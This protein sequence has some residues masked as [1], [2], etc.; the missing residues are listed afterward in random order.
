MPTENPELNPPSMLERV[1]LHYFRKRSTKFPARQGDEVYLLDADEMLALKRIE[2]LAVVRAAIAGATSAAIAAAACYFADPLL[3]ELPSDA[4]FAQQWKYWLI[5][6]GV[7]CV[8]TVAEILFLYWDALRTVHTLACAAGLDLFPKQGERSAVVTSLV[9][10]AL[11]LPLPPETNPNVQ[12]GRNTSW[13]MLFI[14]PLIYKTK[15]SLTSFLIKAIVRR[16]A[17]R[18]ITRAWIEFVAVPVCAIWNAVVC[19]WI[20]REARYRAMGPS[21]IK[22]CLQQLYDRNPDLS[23]EDRLI[24]LDAVASVISRNVNLHPNV[25]RLY[26]EVEN[27]VDGD[28]T[29]NES[30]FQPEQFLSQLG[31][32]SAKQQEFQIGLL[33]LASIIDGHLSP[34]ELELVGDA[35]EV[36]GMLRDPQRLKMLLAFFRS[37]QPIDLG[38]LV[39]S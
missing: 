20:I 6:M 26:R 3:D 30:E 37:G 15:V 16:Y 35:R 7:T 1:G 23:D 5:V 21:A 8:V 13:L 14:A 18:V 19:W 9:Q 17:G 28:M 29:L 11:E 33:E 38:E 25:E 27:S 22:Y 32:L 2:R 24:A 4:G 39:Y 10:A 34:W 36:C 12:P 31:N